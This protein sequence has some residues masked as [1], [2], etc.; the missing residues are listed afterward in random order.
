MKLRLD[1]YQQAALGFCLQSL[2]G[3]WLDPVLVEP[4]PFGSAWRCALAGL[5]RRTTGMDRELLQ[6]RNA[7]AGPPGPWNDAWI[8]CPALGSPIQPSTTARPCR[9]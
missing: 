5:A 8:A 7:V 4:W 2:A 9:Q 6:H 3:L 1:N